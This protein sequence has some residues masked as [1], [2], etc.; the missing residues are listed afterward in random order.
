MLLPN[1]INKAALEAIESHLGAKNI[2]YI[3]LSGDTHETEITQWLERPSTEGIMLS[4]ND[5]N[6]AATSMELSHLLDK[7]KTFLFVPGMSTSTRGALTTIP[8]ETLHFLS[9]LAIPIIPVTIEELGKMSLITQGEPPQQLNIQ[10]ASTLPFDMEEEPLDRLSHI[11]ASWLEERATIISKQNFVQGSLTS[12]LI[13]GLKNNPY[14]R[15]IDGID[16]S[17]FPYYQLL[18][19]AIAF[20]KH[21]K[22]LTQRRRVGIILP[23]GKGCIL[24]NL[25]C[26]FAG[27]IPVNFNFTASAE[28]I[29]SCIKQSEVDRFI[30]ADPF[31][32]R[33]PDFPWPPMRD[34]ILLE[35]ERVKFQNSAKR[36]ILISRFFSA[37]TLIKWLDADNF[38][39][40]DEAILLFT[41]GSSG[42]PKGVPLTH[43]NIL[44]N[45]SQCLS[46]I[47]LSDNARLLA[48]LPIFHSFGC[49]I[50]MFFPLIKGFDI[51]SYP[52]PKEAKR[53]GELVEKYAVELIVTTPT[54]MR[55]MTRRL[56]AQNFNKLRYLIAGAEKLSPD[57][58]HSFAEKFG[59]YPME[60]YGLTEASP[61]CAANIP[62]PTQHQTKPLIPSQELGSVGQ[63]LPG[64]AIKITDITHDDPYPLNKTGMIWLKGANIFNGYLRHDRHNRKILQDGW[65]KTGDVGHM[66][67]NGFLHIEGRISRFSKIAG[68]MIPHEQLEIA[69]IRAMHLNPTDSDRHIAIMSIP[70]KQKGEALVLLTTV[71]GPNLQQDQM[72]LHY[73]LLEQGIPAL[74]SPKYILPVKEIPML[75][76]GKLDI[77]KCE[78][79][80]KTA[81]E[82]GAF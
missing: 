29:A 49:T 69:I 9:S 14:A 48:S 42:T 75:P 51:V 32:R 10:I 46:R 64:V 80:L 58:A 55:A 43:K 24:A 60:G 2:I 68:E 65:F 25:A 72:V 74:W 81:R 71:S 36:W 73:A 4:T 47:D 8:T 76:S 77:M 66:D 56:P 41:S 15:L 44:G 82:N 22:T 35:Q 3:I 78:T 33:C 19:A 61:V 11:Q 30:T 1:R 79:I 12:H 53:I 67:K 62:T 57:L 38:H 52:S 40:D 26:L 39:N 5:T 28:A 70:D 17:S 13:R 6:I 37:D 45:I 20:S 18:G 54:F 59:F 27:K 16:D 34:L 50:T 31:V 7:E 21:L 63:P 23:A